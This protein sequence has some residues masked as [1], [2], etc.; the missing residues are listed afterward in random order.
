[1]SMK[2]DLKEANVAH[3]NLSGFCQVEAGTAVRDVLTIM[4]EAGRGACLILQG[5]KLVGIFTERDVLHKVMNTP[6]MLD[7][8]VDA[9]MTPNPRV[10]TPDISAAAALTLMDTGR[11]RN[12]PV[13]NEDGE[14]LGDMTY[15]A[16][17]DYLAN[18]YPIAVLNRP[19]NP[20][21]FPRKPEG[22]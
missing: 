2:K 10:I 21:Q 22:G 3:L 13:V 12:L 5:A 20:E 11:F 8:P 19:P 17:I 15:Q 4:R 6:A 7:A 14:V 16:I 18:L 9:V 1:M